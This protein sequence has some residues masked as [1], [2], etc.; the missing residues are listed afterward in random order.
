MRG[1]SMTERCLSLLACQEAKL[2]HHVLIPLLD[3]GLEKARILLAEFLQEA[4][5]C[6]FILSKCVAKSQAQAHLLMAK[7]SIIG[8]AKKKKMHVLDDQ[9]QAICNEARLQS[10]KSKAVE[11]KV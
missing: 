4:R 1:S 8:R 3:Q 9:L 6:I 2:V 5:E 11:C 7:W 10:H